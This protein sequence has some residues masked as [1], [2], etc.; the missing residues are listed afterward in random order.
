ML[1]S[2]EFGSYLAY[3]PRGTSDVSIRSRVVRDAVKSWHV[4]RMDAALDRLLND[5]PSTPLHQVL[6][7][8]VILIPV[9]RSAPLIAGALWP[10]RELCEGLV[11]RGLGAGVAQIL[12]RRTAVQK[13]AYAKS[14]ERPRLNQHY[15]SMA[16]EVELLTSRRLT[17]IDDIVTKGTT[18]LAATGRVAETYTEE[19]IRGFALARTLGLV[20]DIERM[21]DPVVG[22]IHDRFGEGNRDP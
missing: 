21:I 13:A 12:D 3:S 6:G 10:S 7:E 18:L 5:F 9:P 15:D 2:V 8:D 20:S 16:V 11:Q 17:L 4:E 1:S 19:T 22:T 14:G